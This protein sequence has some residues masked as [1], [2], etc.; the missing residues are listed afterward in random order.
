MRIGDSAGAAEKPTD[1]ANSVKIGLGPKKECTIFGKE[2][3]Y[4][5]IPDGE[6]VIIS[7]GYVCWADGNSSRETLLQI[8]NSF[9]E[10]QIGDLKKRLVGEYTLL[11]KKGSKICIFS[12]FMGVRNL[13]YSDDGKTVS[14]SFSRLEDTLGTGEGDLDPYKVV[15]FIAMKKVL[16]AAWLGS[17]TYHRRIKWLL[18][19]EYLVFDTENGGFRISSVVYSIDN[20][21]QHDC[22]SLSNELVSILTQ[23]IARRE[24]KQLKVAASLTGGHDS[25]LV[26]AIA[27]NEFPS[28]HFR[29]AASSGSPSTLKDLKISRKVAQIQHVP[30]DV[31]WFKPERDVE[32]F[33]ELTEGFSP[34]FNQTI[35][36][37]L[38]A[39]GTY[40]LGFGGAFG[41]E[42]F[43]ELPWNSIDAFIEAKIAIS[44]QTLKMDDG[45][46]QVFR[47]S[48]QGE[49][50]RIKE[51][52]HLTISD[53][54]DYIRLFGLVVTARYGSFILS[55]FNRMGYYFDP[56][57]S[58]A[59]TDLALRVPPALWGNHRRLGG[60]SLVQKAAMSKVNRRAGRPLTYNHFRPML[61]LRAVTF[62]KYLLGY[63]L[64]IGNVIAAR[65][66]GGRKKPDRTNLPGGYYLSDG[67][68]A[69]YIE[70]INIRYGK[71][72]IEHPPI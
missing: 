49:F 17:S 22:S 8:L 6:D 54:R 21:K 30:L 18:P 26:A 20:R 66:T 28:I 9:Q 38:D 43:M 68:E 58:Y 63:G 69:R 70:R 33:V 11:V 52:F 46:W 59:V 51:H 4:N 35:T 34:V 31:F 56:Y 24:F 1:A 2:G 53:D 60:N 15:E 48:L 71:L 29:T 50:L 40:A 12:D 55:A 39:A 23:I 10:S 14:S 57:G 62:P 25:R 37:L 64:Q 19:Y 13:F 61:P 67:W 47:E 3:T 42:S 5:I 7:L 45:F 41:T 36:P 72:L 27:R 65:Y 44:K 32:R 16:Y